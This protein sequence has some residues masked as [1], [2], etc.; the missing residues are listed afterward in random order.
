MAATA[1]EIAMPIAEDLAE[2]KTIDSAVSIVSNAVPL[3]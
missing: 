2:H 1:L 3:Q